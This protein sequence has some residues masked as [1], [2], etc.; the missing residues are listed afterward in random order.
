MLIPPNVL[1]AVSAG[2]S[3]DKARWQLNGV[4]LERVS[5]TKS[6]ATATCGKTLI[7][8]E[9][10]EPA[11]GVYPGPDLS[12]EGTKVIIPI[13]DIP[14]LVKLAPDDKFTK[15][16]LK[17][18]AMNEHTL[19][20][21]ATFSGTN[22]HSTKTSTIEPV[23]GQYPDYRVVLQDKGERTIQMRVNPQLLIKTLKAVQD[24]AEV[25][26]VTLEF[27]LTKEDND[28]VARAMRIVAKN[29]TAWEG[30]EVSGFVMP[31]VER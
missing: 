20:G 10:N 21:T 25:E 2:A 1:K 14:G 15:P 8:A 12:K 4:Y 9:W 7:H 6:A 31:K 17:Y 16:D 27:Y 28:Q 3:K 26:T 24:A 23:D 13:T 29:N 18:L 11:P 5:P 22:G 30:V 19:N